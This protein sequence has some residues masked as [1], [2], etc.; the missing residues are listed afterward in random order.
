MTTKERLAIIG[1]VLVSI[2]F[3][4]ILIWFL[5]VEFAPRTAATCPVPVVNVYV[6]SCGCGPRDGVRGGSV[7]SPTKKSGNGALYTKPDPELA[8]CPPP[9]TPP[10]SESVP[11]IDPEP[12]PTETVPVP[13]P[14]PIP[15]PGPGPSGGGGSGS[16]RQQRHRVPELGSMSALA[17]GG[18]V[19]TVA[20]WLRR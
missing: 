2:A 16:Y 18:L 14:T 17:V 5:F 15:T 7:V 8:P 3:L 20:K 13:T 11:R 4:I 10:Y 19:I 9:S 6:N 1:A 12:S